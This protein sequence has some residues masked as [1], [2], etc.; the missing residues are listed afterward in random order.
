MEW[1]KFERHRKQWNDK[2]I[3]ITDLAFDIYSIFGLLIKNNCYH[4]KIIKI[5]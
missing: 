5:K 3:K 1:T 4:V 2:E